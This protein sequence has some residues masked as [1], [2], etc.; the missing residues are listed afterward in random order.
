MWVFSSLGYRKKYLNKGS[1]LLSYANTAVYP[2]Y[3]FY[4][5]VIVAIAYY[6]VG[7]RDDVSLKLLFLLITVSSLQERDLS[8]VYPTL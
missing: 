8:F 7:T 3:I 1:R 2:F 4:Q 6:V 5:T